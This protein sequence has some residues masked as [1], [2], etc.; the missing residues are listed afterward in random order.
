MMTSPL[1]SKLDFVLKAVSMNRARLAAE[2]GVD[3]AT[4]GRWVNGSAVPASHNL[5][6]L[7][8]LIA[9]RIEGFNILDWERDLD[10]LAQLIGVALPGQAAPP[11]TPM[12]LSGLPLPL[13]EESFVITRLRGAAYEGFYRSTRPYAQRP[14]HYIHDQFML[15]I[16][17][18]GAMSGVMNSAG[19]IVQGWVML[20]HNQLFFIGSETTSG[21][22]AFSI[23]NGVSTVKA[24]VMDG[25]VLYCALD[26]GHTPT[27]SRSLLER[28]GDLTGDWAADNAH[29][30]SLDTE[31]CIFPEA[32]ISPEL[33]AHLMR[34][35]GSAQLPIGGD[36]LLSLPLAQSM[37]R[38][39]SPPPRG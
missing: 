11:A 26:I 22:F 10:G 25:I 23:F 16:E 18:N 24:A 36:W 39:L 12:T 5:S 4:V 2:L 21:A 35:F 19:V 3:K 20:L 6:Q 32:A 38:G 34:D 27:A 29:F 9:S 13:I 31:N 7:T 1:A 28:T 15:R 37:A 14:G 30:A 33:R 17:P 8:A